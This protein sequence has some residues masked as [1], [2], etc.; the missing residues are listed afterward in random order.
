[1]SQS[2]TAPVQMQP[3]LV[4]KVR[5]LLET[6][7]P[8]HTVFA[9]PF[10]YM[11]LFLAEDGL[12]RF[13]VLLWIT[14]AF[15]GARFAGMA[16]NRLADAD[17]DKR[18]PRN[19]RRAIPAGRLKRLEV[20]L[21]IAASLG[22]FVGSSYQL[23]FWPS[24]L[25]PAVVAALVMSPYPKRFFWGSNL[26]IGLVYFLIPSGVWVAARGEI[27]LTPVL[28]GVSSALWNTGFDT[29]YRCQDAEVDR[30]L[31]LHSF[32][33]D[34][35]V[36]RALWVAR[37]MHVGTSTALLVLGLF[38]HV[39]P[40]YYAGLGVAAMCFVYQHRLVKP[41]DLSRLNRAF[42]TMNGLISM[43]HF[44]FVVVDTAVA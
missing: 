25:W 13:H 10:A 29:L 12:P 4:R 5:D 16:I 42:F 8:E 17:L 3:L 41:D 30:R 40:W 38:L 1:M 21:F 37:L 11:A 2:A 24:V 28:L 33:A 39:G 34:F 23:G 14:L 36:A 19:Q 43:V 27:G 35:G 22:L 26:S 20:L 15:T 32:A 7:R 18:I 44:V 6:V 31:G 9:L